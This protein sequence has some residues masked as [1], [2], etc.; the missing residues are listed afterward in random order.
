MTMMRKIAG[1]LA[2]AAALLAITLQPMPVHA[3]TFVSSNG[4]DTNTCTQ[5][6]PC[7]TFGKALSVA[8]AGGVIYCLTPGDFGPLIIQKA[9]TIDCAST[10]A[11]ISNGFC[12]TFNGSTVCAAITVAAG[13]TD[14]V[15]LRGL[16]LITPAFI[17]TENGI[18]FISGAALHVRNCMIGSYEN[19]GFGGA[20]LSG[21]GIFFNPSGGATAELYVQD[22]I[23]S[24]NG[25]TQSGG[26]IVVQPTGSSSAHVE[27]N[28]VV[29]ERNKYGFF[30]NGNNSTGVIAVQI[31]DSVVTGSTFNGISA[32]TS[33]A[34]TAIT[35]D[36]SSSNLNGGVGILAQGSA[37]FVFLKDA[38]VMS[39]QTGLSASG[40]S[41]I[42]YQNN[43]L[44]G[45]VND[46]A[47]TR[48]LAL[49]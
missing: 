24:D 41:I 17:L 9:I 32:F 16:S 8:S 30:A 5:A 40:G 37:A 43:S 25:L 47:P 19:I 2:C 1:F 12:P 14:V 34:A 33:S 35:V 48:T 6:G 3:Q 15:T 46:G 29:M 10:G 27:L 21:I 36:H 20:G 13:A 42:S 49:Q 31:R 18:R 38:T 28:R 44:M 39:N 7:L 26:G 11:A 22:T 23:I 45:N 4:L